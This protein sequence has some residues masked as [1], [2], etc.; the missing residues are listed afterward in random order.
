MRN[1]QKFTKGCKMPHSP[2][3]K[4]SRAGCTEAILISLA[5]SIY[6]ACSI[7]IFNVQPIYPQY[8]ATICPARKRYIS[9]IQMNI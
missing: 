1:S 5:A 3:Y 2:P 6:P 7:Y 8:T 9:Y 4:G